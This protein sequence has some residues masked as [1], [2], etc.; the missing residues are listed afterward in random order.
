MLSD[1]DI[2]LAHPEAFDFAFS[3]LPPAKRGDFDRHLSGCRYCQNVVEEYSEIGR[4]LKDLPPHVEPPADL[5]ERTVAAMIAAV[6]EQRAKLEHRSDIQ[7]R[8][9]T[10]SYPIPRHRQA[11]EAE[12]RPWQRSQIARPAEPKPQI[13]PAAELTP[14]SRPQPIV[15]RLPVWRRHPR[16]F[17]AIAAATSIAAIIVPLS[18]TLGQAAPAA[19]T[20]IIPLHA[21]TA[22]KVSGIGAATGQATA[23]QDASGSWHISLTVHHLKD[24]GDAQW[25]ECWYRNP[26]TGQV[27]SAGTFL[28]PDNGTGTFPMTAAVDPHDFTIMEITLGPPSKTGALHGKPVLSGTAKQL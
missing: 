6:G 2:E 26:N 3:N 9:A 21:T 22:A 8:T 15:R 27:A 25:Y 4:I 13:P 17:A 24:F 10:Q 28:V 16:R 7:D 11:E 20:V 12:T 5:E 14:Q 1:R 19:A 23:R 18:L